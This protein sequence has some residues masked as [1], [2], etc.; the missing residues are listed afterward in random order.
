MIRRKPNKIAHSTAHALHREYHILSILRKTDIPVPNVYVYCK[1]TTILGSEFYVMELVQG[2]IFVDPCM[3]H[4]SPSYRREAYKDALNV[5]SKIHS[6]DYKNTFKQRGGMFVKRQ[7]GRLWEVYK[8]QSVD[9]GGVDGL[10]GIAARLECYAGYCPN[11]VGLLH[12]DYK[13]DNLIFHPTKPKV[14]CFC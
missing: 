9:V 13:L 1:D 4:T 7:M 6:F 10:E 14:S 11:K 2:R 12:G 3:P 8:K 5:L